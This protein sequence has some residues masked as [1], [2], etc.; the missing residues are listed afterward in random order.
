LV[1]KRLLFCCPLFSG[2]P[3]SVFQS[4]RI[5]FFDSTFTLPF[6]LLCG[7]AKN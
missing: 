2:N 3:I 6:F 1:F 5:T 4:R 7:G